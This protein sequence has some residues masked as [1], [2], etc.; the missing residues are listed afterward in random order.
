MWVAK[1]P[2]FT[3]AVVASADGR[4]ARDPGES[5]SAWASA[6]NRVLFRGDVASADWSIIGRRTHEVNPRPERRRI[7]FSSSAG[8]GDWRRP[9]QLWLD[10]TG[11]VPVDLAAAVEGVRPMRSG[12]IV[13]GTRVY[14]WFRAHD[15][16][17]EVHLTIEP[18]WFG[19]GVPIFSDQ[20]SRDPLAV[21]S[22]AGYEPV[23]DRAIS[24][25]GTRFLVLEPDRHGRG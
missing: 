9:M 22:K 7:V 25:A 21:F 16:I 4:I 15:A 23:Y 17:D 12:L 3:M 11:L 14:D 5:S 10:P 13:G 19:S 24:D 20:S 2:F 6:R 8:T 1:R 18:V